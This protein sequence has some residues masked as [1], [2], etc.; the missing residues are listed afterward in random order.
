MRMQVELHPV[1][2][3][4]LRTCRP[5]DRDAFGAELERVRLD[6]IGNSEPHHDPETSRFMLRYFRFGGYTALFGFDPSRG[7]IR[8]VRC[9]PRKML[10]A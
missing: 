7:L 8:V 5:D 6:P 2:R 10:D 3:L 1:V 9:R 4:F